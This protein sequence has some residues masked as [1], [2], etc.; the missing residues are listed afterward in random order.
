MMSPEA[1]IIA[2]SRHFDHFHFYPYPVA[3][4]T[5]QPF[6]VTVLIFKADRVLKVEVNMTDP[7]P[8][9]HHVRARLAC[10]ANSWRPVE[11]GEIQ[12][13]SLRF[14]SCDQTPCCVQYISLVVHT[15]VNFWSLGQLDSSLSAGPAFTLHLCDGTPLF[16]PIVLRRNGQETTLEKSPW[17]KGSG[18]RA[19]QAQ[20]RAR[21]PYQ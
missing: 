16:E 9:K 21:R 18:G 3:I 11:S 13:A 10:F 1:P 17:R 5:P 20:S 7:K 6:R 4:R 8:K 19:R 12:S 15:A 14:F 2:L